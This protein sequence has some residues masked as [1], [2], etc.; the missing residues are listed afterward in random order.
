MIER[1]QPP[2]NVPDVSARTQARSNALAAFMI[3]LVL[4]TGVF[5]IVEVLSRWQ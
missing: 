3:A 1:P 5:C 4:V 2:E